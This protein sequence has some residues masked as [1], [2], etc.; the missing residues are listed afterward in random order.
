MDFR[1]FFPIYLSILLGFM[2]GVEGGCLVGVFV[3]VFGVFL[4][5]PW[6]IDS[7][8]RNAGAGKRPGKP[9]GSWG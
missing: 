8:D 7:G 2:G 4:L 5:F 3:V 6:D 1:G 9:S